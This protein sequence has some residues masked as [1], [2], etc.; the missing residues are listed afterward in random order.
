MAD[1]F[2]LD[3]VLAGLENPDQS[4][5]QRGMLRNELAKFLHEGGA[6]AEKAEAVLRDWLGN[7]H[8]E[9][10]HFALLVL[11]EQKFMEPE[12]VLK[13]RK[14]IEIPD[15]VVFLEYELGPKTAEMLLSCWRGI[16][17]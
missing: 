2:T 4:I 10:R 6:E 7:P 11:L 9:D 3:E 1:D 17:T 8:A 15:N 12:T 5:H 16:G 13:L 14:A